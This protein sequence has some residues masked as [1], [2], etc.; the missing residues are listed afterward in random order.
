MQIRMTIIIVDQE[1]SLPANSLID[2]KMEISFL[3]NWFYCSS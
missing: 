3:M 2:S 1:N